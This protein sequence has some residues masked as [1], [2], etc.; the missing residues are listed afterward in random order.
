MNWWAAVTTAW[1]GLARGGEV[2]AGTSGAAGA[3]ADLRRLPKR[4]DLSF[5]SA[6][7]RRYAQVMLRPI[8]KTNGERGE[9]VPLLFEESDGGGS[10]TYAALRRLEQ[11]DP[12]PEDQRARTPLFRLGTKPL[13]VSG[14]RR[15]ARRLMRAAGQ[16]GARVGAHSMRIGGATDLADQDAS[17][18]LL[19]AKGRWSSDI[20]RIYARMT[21]RAQLAASR[22]M[23]RRGARDL[24]EIFPT[25]AQPA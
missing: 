11:H 16:S 24:E 9:K 7:G 23:Q 8:K 1:Q 10:D 13:S 25:F 6:H 19:Q 14:L 3:A 2:A 18:L 22:M 12:V 21:R 5:G 20:G 15:F 17:P 4:A